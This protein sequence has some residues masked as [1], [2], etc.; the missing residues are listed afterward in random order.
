MAETFTSHQ[1][2]LKLAEKYQVLYIEALYS[3]RYT[4][5]SGQPAPF[6]IVHG[7][8]GQHLLDYPE[9]IQEI[10]PAIKSKD[11][12]GNENSSS[13]WRRVTKLVI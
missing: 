11:L 1:F 6:L 7:I 12:S 8:L 13:Y 3:Y 9:L 2:I 4:L 10:N 5:R